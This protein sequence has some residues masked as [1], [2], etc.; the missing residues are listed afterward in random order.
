MAIEKVTTPD[1][2]TVFVEHVPT[3]HTLSASLVVKSGSIHEPDEL[4]GISH[5]LE[6]AV[7]LKT[8]QFASGRHIEEFADANSVYMNASTT[9]NRT[10]FETSGLHS[11]AM[12][13]ILGQAAFQPLFGRS[14]V[15]REMKAVRREA[16]GD[17]ED[18]DELA[19]IFQNHVLFG[20]PFGRNIIGYADKLHF[21]ERQLKDYYKR[22]YKVGNMALIVVGNIQT[23]EVLS[24]VDRHFDMSA[25][26]GETN[27]LEPVPIHGYTSGTYGFNREDSDSARIAVSV[28]RNPEINLRIRESVGAYSTAVS[29]ISQRVYDELREKRG[30]S[31]D[32][33]FVNYSFLHTS[34]ARISANVT[35]DVDTVPKA[36]NLIDKVL[37]QKVKTYSDADIERK[38]SMR[39]MRS[40]FKVDNILGRVDSYS[41]RFAYGDELISADQLFEEAKNV[42]VDQVRTALEYVLD[43]WGNQEKFTFIT[44][45]KAAVSKHTVI[46][47]SQFA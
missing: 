2:L 8:P 47:Q 17:L 42:T 28:R 13:R 20:L 5:A 38:L 27:T 3:V 10:E 33:D 43:F 15:A 31:Y 11:D 34:A 36:I 40:A 39:A 45:P 18:V 26:Q 9:Y 21:N 16:K 37:S 41:S 32:G 12:F 6:H 19:D 1:N 46:D 24:M 7:F 29:L 30:L 25:H 23:D 35:T 22:N 4:A 14:D 44:G